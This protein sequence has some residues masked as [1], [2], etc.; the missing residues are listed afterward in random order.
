[1]VAYI[2]FLLVIDSDHMTNVA[3]LIPSH[4]AMIGLVT[5][6]VDL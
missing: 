6:T 3:G 1:M 4:A 2:S 5:F